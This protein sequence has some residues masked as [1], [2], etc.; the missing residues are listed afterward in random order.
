[1]SHE[2]TEGF[3]SEVG[4]PPLPGTPTASR[5]RAVDLVGVMGWVDNSQSE[6]VRAP[7][8]SNGL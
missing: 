7:V 5:Q 4:A 8:R 1:M 2:R 3:L 6:G